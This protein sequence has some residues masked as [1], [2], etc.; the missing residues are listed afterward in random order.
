MTA[1]RPR[2][3]RCIAAVATV[4]PA[5]EDL[6]DTFPA[7]LF[8]LATGFGPASARKATLAC[9]DR[10]SSLREACATLGL[11]LWTRRLPAEA[12]AEPLPAFPL[13]ADFAAIMVARVP[14]DSRECRVWLDRLTI[15]LQLGGRDLAMWFAREPRLLP[16]LTSDDDIRWLLAW[17]WTSLAPTSPGRALLRAAWTP[18][19]GWKRARDEV[20]I[21]RKRI[22][23]VGALAGGPGD[24]W[25]RDG[26]ALGIDIVHIGSVEALIN[27]SSMM[28][29][30]L[31]QYAPHLA[32]GRVRV[33]SVRR[34]GKPIADVEL[35]LRSDEATMPCIA[36]IRGP[37]NRRAPPLVWQAV[38]AWLGA[39]PFRPITA[40][41]TAPA[42]SR[43][44]LRLFWRPYADALA[45]LGLEDRL[46]VPMAVREGR[47]GRLRQLAPRRRA[48]NRLA[49]SELPGHSAPGAPGNERV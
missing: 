11:P 9:I 33:F 23:L 43:E 32:Y 47:G 15:A 48:V 21:W 37:R 12:L 17:A 16:P 8:A 25:F 35:T 29:N 18:S 49:P 7:L 42:A 45:K 39:Q 40:T 19:I 24:P 20:A 4:C 6:A 34:D 10:G 30:C 13:D 2:F 31:D 38:H 28:E 41:P 22:E 14:E 46:A 27:E 44:A 26:R 36:Q 5:A 1:F 3:R